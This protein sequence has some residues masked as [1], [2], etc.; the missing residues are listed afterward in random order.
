M[1]YDDGKMRS[2]KRLPFTCQKVTF[3]KPICGLLQAKR[4]HIG[5]CLIAGAFLRGGRPPIGCASAKAAPGGNRAATSLVP[6]VRQKCLLPVSSPACRYYT[7]PLLCDKNVSFVLR[8]PLFTLSLQTVRMAF[9]AP[10]GGG[11]V[12]RCG[13]KTVEAKPTPGRWR[14]LAAGRRVY[15]DNAGPLYQ[16]KRLSCALFLTA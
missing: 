3:Y 15:G 9:T 4:R 7:L 6:S 12:R 1:L 14:L 2:R 11:S 10:C 16:G 5:K 8:Y 13:A